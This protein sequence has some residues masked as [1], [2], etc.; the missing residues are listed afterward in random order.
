M[1]RAVTTL[2]ALAC[3]SGLSFAAGGT[4][5]ATVGAPTVI[6]AVASYQSI[7]ETADWENY[8]FTR[9]IEEKFNV[10]LQWTAYPANIA[11]E[12]IRIA[13]AAGELPDMLYGGVLGPIRDDAIKTGQFVMLDELIEKGTGWKN[14]PYWPVIKPVVTQTD[15]HIYTLG[16][17]APAPASLNGGGRYFWNVKWMQELGI[18]EPRSIAE[19]D[20]ALRAVKQ[21]HPD[22]I[23]ISGLYN[24]SRQIHGYFMNAFGMKADYGPG[25]GNQINYINGKVVFTMAHP[26]YRAYLTYMS[27]LYRDGYLDPEYFTQTNAQM[28]ARAKERGYFL[29]CEASQSTLLGNVDQVFDYM[30]ATPLTSDVNPEAWWPRIAPVFPNALAIPSTSKNVEKVW[31]IADWFGTPEGVVVSRGFIP[32]EFYREELVPEG[33]SKENVVYT[34]GPNGEI[35]NPTFPGNMGA[36]PHLNTYIAP[37]GSNGP[38]VVGWP[39]D[40]PYT[41]YVGY[42][43]YDKNDYGTMFHY[44]TD[45]ILSPYYVDMVRGNDLKFT[46]EEQEILQQYSG[47]LQ[48]YMDEMHAKFIIGTQPLS[49]YDNYL[50]ELPRYGLEQAS[51]VYTA[52][53]KRYL[54]SK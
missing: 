30:N 21:A 22:V 46:P 23:P 10:E 34:P 26:N 49:E 54:A 41:K 24:S 28:V 17:Y 5:A 45:K 32:A 40:S 3:V 4:E 14:N 16:N 11:S 42:Q 37:L 15:G 19:L 47:E 53:Y 7:Q 25:L 18:Q 36:W 6:T 33:L 51:E 29:F 13:F 35:V 1:R 12:R 9:Y 20:V 38:W 39:Q 52:S 44:Y 50:K 43:T 27:G 31:E 8:Y 2:M 48:S